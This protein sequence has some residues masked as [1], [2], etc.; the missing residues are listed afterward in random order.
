[1]QHRYAYRSGI[2]N[3]FKLLL[4][5]CL[6]TSFSLVNAQIY[7]LEGLNLPGQ[8][9]NFVNPPATGSVFGSSTQALGTVHPINT[10]TRRW[11]TRIHIADSGADTSAGTYSF[12][13]T[14][15]PNATPYANKWAGVNVI[16]DSLQAYQFNAGADNSI[17]VQN[18]KVYTMNWED[19]GYQANRAIFMETSSEPVSLLSQSTNI[20]G[21]TVGP[22]TPVTATLLLSAIPSP[23]EKFYLRYSTDFYAT[24]HIIPVSVIGSTGTA[25]IPG[26][27]AGL[28][29]SYYYFS[30]T[31]D[32]PTANYDLL[33]LDFLNDDG[34]N[35]LYGVVDP[36]L[37][38]GLGD[39]ILACPGNIQDTL[40][41]AGTY[42]SYLWSDSS[43]SS[44]LIINAP[45]TYWLET[46]IGE[47]T[48]RDSIT[49]SQLSLAPIDL[50]ESG[51]I[52]G[53][54]P[55]ELFP[56]VKISPIGDSLTIVYDATQGQS[57]LTGATSVYMHSSFEYA[58]LSGAEEPWV[59]NWGV[60]D[61]LG[62]M[63]NIGED[64]WSITIHVYDYYGIDPDSSVNGLFIVFRNA[65]GTATGKDENGNDIF[66]GLYQNP[67][68]SAFTGISGTVQ[69]SGYDEILWSTG[70]TSPSILV[71]EAG[72][73][74]VN[75][76]SYLGCSLSD[77]I[78]VITS[79]NP[80]INLGAD[81]TSCNNQPVTIYATGGFSSYY[82]SNGTTTQ[83]LTTAVAGT[84]EITV[85]NA[86]GCSASD[87]ISVIENVSPTASFST[88]QSGLTVNITNAST[89][90]ATY[91]WDFQNNGSVDNT[92]AGDVSFT[93]PAPG[94]YLIRLIVSNYCGAD[95][96][97]KNVTVT[98]VGIEQVAAQSSL[99]I[100]PNPTTGNLTIQS[101][102]KDATLR[103]HSSSG[104]LIGEMNAEEINP[105]GWN[106]LQDKA[107]GLYI[108][109]EI[110]S[111]GTRIW[112]IILIKE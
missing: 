80:S 53:G 32:N 58:P 36:F 96:A 71:S 2:L 44:T 20:I 55:L 45:G 31:I 61:G 39:D 46:T 22:Q 1:M 110:S 85:T 5:L 66:L 18:N 59:G 13:F 78:T 70:E 69:S 92:T 28:A 99:V 67:P 107:P 75:M 93:Y 82:W 15:G 112:P 27:A 100:Y 52:C 33:T 103:I 91:A 16:I 42:D 29:V 90:T 11:Q 60:N 57:T 98:D 97:F 35:F 41:T 81:R 79:P 83:G 88:V 9:N 109:Q 12:L 102:S 68:Y 10:G 76:S 7:E 95:T 17:T 87:L 106:I 50:G 6:T 24:S 40:Q 37:S 108:L 86:A 111:S 34:Y 38:F 43:T 104:L 23:E 49:I 62:E 21:T 30:T 64:L 63:T 54:T 8:W 101:K 14:S 25:T 47:E 74:W 3:S 51:T 84:Y 89:L 73:Y 72:T 94:Q 48:H 105:S 77:T 26:F 65:T 19:R 56:G 4:L